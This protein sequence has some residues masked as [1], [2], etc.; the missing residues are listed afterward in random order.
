MTGK[1]E[2]G[3]IDF[4]FTIDHYNPGNRNEFSYEQ[5]FQGEGNIR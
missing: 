2:K 4:S 1:K 3:V 5:T